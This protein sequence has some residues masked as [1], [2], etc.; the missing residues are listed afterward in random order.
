MIILRN[1]LTNSNLS[2]KILAIFV[3]I[4][5]K[6]IIIKDLLIN[7]PILKENNPIPI[8]FQILIMCDHNN[9]NSIM[10]IFLISILRISIIVYL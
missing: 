1:N 5:R 3:R 7:P 8:T 4:E 2:I 10:N 9:S 6:L